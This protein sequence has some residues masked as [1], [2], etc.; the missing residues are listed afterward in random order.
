LRGGREGEGEEGRGPIYNGRE[1]RGG[2]GLLLRETEG[3]EGRREGIKME[4]EKI[5]PENQGE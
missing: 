4:G 2:E 1:G 5:F 3:R